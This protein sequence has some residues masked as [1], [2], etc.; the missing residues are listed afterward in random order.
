MPAFSAF[1]ATAGADQLANLAPASGTVWTEQSNPKDFRLNAVD[2]DGTTWCALGITDGTDTYMVTSTDAVTWTEKAH[3]TGTTFM[4]GIIFAESLWVAV[5][6]ADGGDS[7]IITATS[8]TGTW[9]ERTS[10]TDSRLSDITHGNGVF[11]AVGNAE[12]AEPF[13]VYSLNGT[14]SWTRGIVT[15]IPAD[16]LI[17]VAYGAGVFC[18][19]GQTLVMSSSDDGVNWT[20]R[21]S[22]LPRSTE[23]MNSIIWDGAQFVALGGN[24]NVWTSSNGTTSWTELSTTGYDDSNDQGASIEYDG[25]GTYVI[26]GADPTDGMLW[27]STDLLAWT[28]QTI[29]ADINTMADITYGD[30]WV[31]VGL[32]GTDGSD[33]GILTASGPA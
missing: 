10:P 26:A 27:T 24:G 8:A 7:K 13:A 6:N 33:A 9:T 17:D 12:G 30:Q 16:L 32:H 29:D 5:G 28:P 1:N 19:V 11:V 23:I 14:T 3:G 2:F 4:N 21:T 15:S 20:D 25:T 18:A 22:S 31:A